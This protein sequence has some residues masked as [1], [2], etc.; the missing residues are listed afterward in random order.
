MV[1]DAYSEYADA[2]WDFLMM[3]DH[4]G[5]PERERVWRAHRRLLASP[6]FEDG[7]YYALVWDVDT[8]VKLKLRTMRP[9]LRPTGRRSPVH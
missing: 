3:G 7:R 5:D 6:E 1:A 9:L 8:K 2:L 4:P